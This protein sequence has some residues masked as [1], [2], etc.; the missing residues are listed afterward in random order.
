MELLAA[1]SSRGHAQTGIAYYWTSLDVIIFGIADSG[2]S[3]GTKGNK[4]AYM[5]MIFL[6]KG[7]CCNKECNP[8][9]GLNV[10]MDNC[11]SE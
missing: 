6:K 11:H 2:N 5:L 4:V 7:Q 1:S 3:G 8:E 10:I 9:E